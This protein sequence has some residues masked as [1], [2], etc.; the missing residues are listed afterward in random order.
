[1]TG[2][3]ALERRYRRLLAW[4][5][6]DHRRTFGEEMVGVL[7]AASP[8]G[9]RRPGLAGAFDLVSGGLR[10]RFRSGARWL[11][12]TDWPDALALCSVTVPVILAGY[13]TA[14]WLHD[15]IAG[16][17]GGSAGHWSGQAE[18]GLVVLAIV[19]VWRSRRR[20]AA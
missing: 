14:Q 15:V 17:L 3:G 7:L 20:P 11:A 12:G 19:A 10:A 8:E 9:S 18:R 1:M 13:L 2:E 5:P 4:Y 6:A 16:A